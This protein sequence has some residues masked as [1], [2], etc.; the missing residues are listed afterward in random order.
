M[1]N[2]KYKLATALLIAKH[3]HA[4]VLF[5]FNKYETLRLHY[6]DLIVPAID[7]GFVCMNT[8]KLFVH[9]DGG[10]LTLT[11]VEDNNYEGLAGIQISHLLYDDVVDHRAVMFLKSKVRTPQKFLKYPSGTYHSYGAEVIIDY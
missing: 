7:M 6:S 3:R 1:K 4:R 5:V 8:S 11:Y 9:P 10:T 2:N